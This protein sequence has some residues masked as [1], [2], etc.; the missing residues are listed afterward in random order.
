M[1]STHTSA[2]S[3]RCCP[4]RLAGCPV[5][6]QPVPGVGSLLSLTLSLAPRGTAAPWAGPEPPALGHVGVAQRQ[7]RGA[8]RALLGRQLGWAGMRPAQRSALSCGLS[9]QSGQK[10]PLSWRG[11]NQQECLCQQLLHRLT[12]MHNSGS[13]QLGY[14]CL[15]TGFHVF[16]HVSPTVRLTE[17]KF[18]PLC[19]LHR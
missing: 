4:A 2:A 6:A 18:S 8:E 1:D 14:L 15:L 3:A 10:F 17:A 7:P 9:C 13:R 5:L 16:T 19:P 12:Q 11:E